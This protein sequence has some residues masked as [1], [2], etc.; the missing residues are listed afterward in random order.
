MVMD[1]VFVEIDNISV[2][3]IQSSA[4]HRTYC[5]SRNDSTILK[6]HHKDILSKSKLNARKCTSDTINSKIKVL[7]DSSHNFSHLKDT[8]ID[9]NVVTFLLSFAVALLIA[10]TVHLTTK[11]EKIIERSKVVFER[12]DI[13][14]DFTRIH[15]VYSESA[16]LWHIL[17]ASN[18]VLTDEA[19]VMIARIDREAHS[20]LNLFLENS[21]MKQS[22][23]EKRRLVETIRDTIRL[24]EID[25][26][27]RVPENANRML[28][29][30]LLIEHLEDLE[31]RIDGIKPFDET[32]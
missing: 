29:I 10:L 20:L 22:E 3:A 21:S 2:G 6:C 12:M 32:W 25:S 31:S 8:L 9:A 19:L 23:S 17:N 18:H 15:V 16:L 13:L 26:L 7:E 24:Y 5:Q 27:K 28:S 4:H 14:K 11:I 1:K 30:E